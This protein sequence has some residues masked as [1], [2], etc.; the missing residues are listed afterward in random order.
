MIVVR[1][2]K[3]A[4]MHMLERRDGKSQQE[5]GADLYCDDPVHPA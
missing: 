2:A 5:S 1:Y 3:R 4:L